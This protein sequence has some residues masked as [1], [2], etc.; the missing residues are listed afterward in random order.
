MTFEDLWKQVSGLPDAAKIQVPGTLSESTKKMLAR[1]K[2]EEVA[3]M[4]AS[5]IGEV[6]RGSIKPLDELIRGRI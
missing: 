1:M 2:P 6:N 4:V 5:A 3:A